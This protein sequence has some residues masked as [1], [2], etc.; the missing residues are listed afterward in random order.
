MTSLGE[1]TAAGKKESESGSDECFEIHLAS[2]TVLLAMWIL[3][4]ILLFLKNYLL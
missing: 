2:S 3:L 4:C 1:K